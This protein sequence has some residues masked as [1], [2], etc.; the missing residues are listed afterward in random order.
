M[1]TFLRIEF[2]LVEAHKFGELGRQ[3]SVE[4]IPVKGVEFVLQPAIKG[5]LEASG[6]AAFSSSAPARLPRPEC[7]IQHL[8]LYP[9]SIRRQ[10]REAQH[11][12]RGLPLG[13]SFSIRPV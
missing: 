5:V 7:T 11:R 4:H 6:G 2:G 3:G 9:M 10:L 12:G 13:P 1:F 8:T